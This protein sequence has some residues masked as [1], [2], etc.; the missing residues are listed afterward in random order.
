MAGKYKKRFTDALKHRDPAYRSLPWWIRDAWEILC[1]EC[2]HLGVW[3]VDMDALV[4]Y[5]GHPVT[6]D[7]LRAAGFKIEPLPCGKKV[8]LPTFVPFQCSDESGLLNPKSSFHQKVAK[9]LISLGLPCP[10][11]KEL[12]VGTPRGGAGTTGGGMGQRKRTRKRKGNIQGGSGGDDAEEAAAAVE[13]GEIE[14]AAEFYRAQAKLKLKL[15]V[16][17]FLKD[18]DYDVLRRLIRLEDMN[19]ERLKK[20]INAYVWMDNEWF[21]TRGRD[22]PT[23]EQNLNVVM[24]EAAKAPHGRSA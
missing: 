18:A 7:D 14:D 21:D 3:I 23:L 4:L 6:L 24:K 1:G 8:F 10:Q 20:L 22:L 2:D 17:P 9:E 12:P 11:F 5:T 13:W 19:L 15:Q 16:P